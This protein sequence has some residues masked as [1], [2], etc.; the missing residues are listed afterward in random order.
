MNSSLLSTDS[1]KQLT[2]GDVEVNFPSL[3]FYGLKCVCWI[4]VFSSG[5]KLS[6][7]KTISEEAEY[8]I[9]S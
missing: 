6:C 3:S 9:L 7:R 5:S 8:K 2:S 1:S 4:N